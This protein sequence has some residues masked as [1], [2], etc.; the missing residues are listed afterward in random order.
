MAGYFDA[1]SGNNIK[2]VKKT[3][4]DNE[5]NLSSAKKSF[6]HISNGANMLREQ[7]NRQYSSKLSQPK[8]W[9]NTLK[10]GAAELQIRNRTNI[11]NDRAEQNIKNLVKT[12][13]ATQT[14]LRNEGLKTLGTRAGT[15]AGAAALTAGGIY[16]KKKIDEKKRQEEARQTYFDSLNK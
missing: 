4:A 8:T 3:L 12:R 14:S 5:A 9:G 10:R 6:T 7:A 15:V 11:L 13:D 2:R 16:I 1:L